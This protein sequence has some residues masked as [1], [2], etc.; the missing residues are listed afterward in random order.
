MRLPDILPA[1]TSSLQIR[2]RLARRKRWVGGIPQGRKGLPLM[3]RRRALVVAGKGATRAVRHR[4][5][6]RVP[7]GAKVAGKLH[8]RWCRVLAKG[9]RTTRRCRLLCRAMLLRNVIAQWA[10]RRCW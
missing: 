1:N 4:V 6:A 7:P 5:R 2:M 10:G 8:N 9:R 3:L